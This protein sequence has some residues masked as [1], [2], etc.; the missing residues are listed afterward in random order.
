MELEY[1]RNIFES[2]EILNFMKIRP[3]RAKLFHAVGKTDSQT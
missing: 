3:V 1:A 2:T